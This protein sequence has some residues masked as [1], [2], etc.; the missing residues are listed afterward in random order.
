M[1]EKTLR[2]G[3]RL[4][5]LGGSYCCSTYDCSLLVEITSCPVLGVPANA[6][7]INGNFSVGMFVYFVCSD[8]YDL[9][10]SNARECRVNGTWSGTQPEC[11]VRNSKHKTM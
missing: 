4:K 10:G 1:R 7:R 6:R 11:M 5:G 9:I 3:L 2:V 8:D